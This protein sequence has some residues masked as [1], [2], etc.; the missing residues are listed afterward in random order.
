MEKLMGASFYP[1]QI[2]KSLKSC[3]GPCQH[4]QKECVCFVSLFPELCGEFNPD[5]ASLPSETF[6]FV[7]TGED[8]SRWFGYCRKLLPEGKGKRLPE[9][10][11][12]VSRLGCFN[13]FSKHHEEGR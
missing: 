7:L 4:D 5:S 11:C 8:G 6:S 1:E 9:V 2:P 3:F 12:I 10:Y 13:L